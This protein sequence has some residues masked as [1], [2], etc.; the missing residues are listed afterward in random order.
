MFKTG[1]EDLKDKH[2]G[3]TCYMVGKGLSLKNIKK[4][5]FGEGVV[6]TLNSAIV[7]IE[8]LEL[9]NQIYAMMKDGGVPDFRPREATLLVSLH[10]SNNVLEDYSP[11]YVFDAITLTHTGYGYKEFSANCALKVAQ[12]MGCNKIKLLCFDACTIGIIKN[13]NEKN[14]VYENWRYTEQCKRMYELIDKE[15]MDVEWIK[16]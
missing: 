10:E 7:Q 14:E 4:E 16:S 8:K 13:I 9:P 5:Y 6:I 1:L 11:R 12:L 2:R 3:E 15:K